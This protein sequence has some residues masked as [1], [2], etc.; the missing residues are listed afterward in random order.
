MIQRLKFSDAENLG[1]TQTTSL[2]WRRQMQ[3]RYRRLNEGMVR[4]CKLAPFNAKRCQ[5]S[6][7]ASLSYWAS[8]LFACSTSDVMQRAVRVCQRQVIWSLYGFEVQR[9]KDSNWSPDLKFRHTRYKISD[10]SVA[11]SVCYSWASYIEPRNVFHC[12][13]FASPREGAKY[14]DLRVCLSCLSI[15]SHI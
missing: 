14:C 15:R 3:V 2:R 6:S 12:A 9:Q 13:I 8:T 1:K 7:V 11:R 10:D 4:S 5:L